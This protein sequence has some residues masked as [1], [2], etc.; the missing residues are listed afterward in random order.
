ME[1]VSEL[2]KIAGVYALGYFAYGG[3]YRFILIPLF[4]PD[5]F[6]R[7]LPGV[8]KLMCCYYT[9]AFAILFVAYSSLNTTWGFIVAIAPLSY[10]SIIGL[11]YYLRLIQR[12]KLSVP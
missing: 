5:G 2:A 12:I 11:F 10:F 6:G 9:G 4:D 8:Y 1:L 7:N 3:V